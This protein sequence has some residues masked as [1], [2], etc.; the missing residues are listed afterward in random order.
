[1]I[2]QRQNAI[3]GNG[4]HRIGSRGVVGEGGKFTI[5]HSFVVPGPAN[6]RVVVRDP[7]V[8]V[9]S[10]SNVLTYEIAQAQNPSLKIES[11][12]DPISYGQSMTIHG[13]VEKLITGTPLR[14]MARP[15]HTNAYTAVSETKVQPGGT[16]AF[17]SQMPLASTFYKV[18]GGGESSAVM[19]E[20]V[21]YL[22]TARISPST[23][24]EQG[25]AVSFS[26]TVKP[27]IAGHVIYLE[28][29]NAGGTGFHV[30]DV[31]RIVEPKAPQTEY[32]YAI[33][34]KFYALG[35]EI[36]RIKIPGDPQNGT[37]VS[38]PFTIQVNPA[39]AAALT[40]EP[41]GNINLPSEGEV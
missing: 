37:T 10:P 3:K 29:E 24:V 1:V 15:A 21:K 4:W 34:H 25:E 12:A 38:E 22:L 17:A 19:Y 2:L 30:I 23:T 6:I 16:Y 20:G 27:G 18:L 14:L 32:T 40:Q 31:G 13:S 41:P 26:G 39:P 8:N 7:G 35:T 9:G 11:S 5:E 28:R 36:V 33:E